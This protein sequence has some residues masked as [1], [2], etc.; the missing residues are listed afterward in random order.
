MN[1]S[2]INN[3]F[4]YKLKKRNYIESF[5]ESKLLSNPSIFK[6]TIKYDIYNSNEN[7]INENTYI[8]LLNK[9]IQNIALIDSET[10]IYSSESSDINDFNI[11]ILNIKEEHIESKKNKKD[12]T[13]SYENEDSNKNNNKNMDNKDIKKGYNL[14][15]NR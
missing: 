1:N 9:K 2:Q 3:S 7:L 14:H 10:E 12:K 6:P 5:P 15:K 13:K 8:E 11:D 4:I